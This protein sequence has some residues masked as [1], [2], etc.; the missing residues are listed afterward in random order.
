KPS[1]RY[2]ICVLPFANMSGDPDQEYFSDGITE[3]IITDLSKVSSLRIISRNSAF[4][5]KGEKL[6]VPQ[7]VR[8]M[9]VTHVLEGSVR[10]AGGRVRISAQLVDCEDNGHV[11]AE[12]YDRDTSDI[13]ALQDEISR[14]R[15]GAA[16][17][18]F[19]GR[20]EGHRTARYRQRR[21]I[22]PVPDGA[23]NVRDWPG[24]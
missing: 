6:D 9:K 8:E 16:A 19:A 22:R 23:A 13:F 18:A 17:A 15:Q 5:Y 1:P 10:K 3:D 21:G 7:L 11:W 24:I 12:R 4:Q 14:H 20:E 2:T